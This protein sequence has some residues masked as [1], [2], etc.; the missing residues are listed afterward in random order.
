MSPVIDLAQRGNM[1]AQ[2]YPTVTPD[3]R[4]SRADPGSRAVK[5]GFWHPWIPAFAGMTQVLGQRSG[6]ENDH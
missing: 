4:R 3:K 1:C 6:S 2:A 5:T